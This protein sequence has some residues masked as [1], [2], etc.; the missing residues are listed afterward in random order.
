MTQLAAELSRRLLSYRNNTYLT[1]NVKVGNFVIIPEGLTLKSFSSITSAIARVLD[2]QRHCIKL[3]LANN[4]TIT[5]QITDILN[6]DNHHPTQYSIDILDLPIFY[7]KDEVMEPE[8]QFCILPNEIN[9]EV[10]H[11]QES[12]NPPPAFD[13][14]EDEIDIQH[15]TSE[16]PQQDNP[17][18]NVHDEIHL[19]PTTTS[20]KKIFNLKPKTKQSK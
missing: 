4:Q 11:G 17:L 20:M 18:L 5:Q 3:K 19:A 7:E 13:Q 1:D 2:V 14:V 16:A 10:I 8:S 9:L 15:I 12:D 6:F